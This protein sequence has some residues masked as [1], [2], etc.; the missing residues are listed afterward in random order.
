MILS[1]TVACLTLCAT[2]LAFGELFPK[3][4]PAQAF[5]EMKIYD[6]TGRPWRAAQEDWA[7]AKQ[8]VASDPAW[9]EWLKDERGTVD[10]WMKKHHDRVEW[11]AG[12]SHDGI[13]PKDGSRLRWTPQIPGE[14]TDHFASP[15]DPRV[16]FTPKLIAW[17][18]VTFR[19][20]HADMIQRAARLYHLT[21]DE[22]YGA[23]AAGQMDFYADNYLKWLPTTENAPTRA[24]ADRARSRRDHRIASDGNCRCHPAGSRARR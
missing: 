9:A 20:Q 4:E 24:G 12:W 18:V 2:T 7:G 17:W 8:R 3:P 6:A 16:E 22:R 23:W 1:R 10:A 14:E 11:V 15:S 19:G 13:S 5:A 21:G